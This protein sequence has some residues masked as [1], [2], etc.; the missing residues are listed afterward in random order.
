M[1]PTYLHTLNIFRELILKVSYKEGNL[2]HEDLINDCINVIIHNRDIKQL[3]KIKESL[4]KY[5]K[6]LEYALIE[7]RY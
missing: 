1:I 6:L 7:S 3:E 4:A 2:L 5:P